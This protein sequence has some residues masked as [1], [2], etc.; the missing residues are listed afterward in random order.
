M[1]FLLVIIILTCALFSN[2]QVTP[3]GEFRVANS[4]TAMGV[5]LPVGTKVYN[6]ADGKYW[7]VTTAAPSTATLAVPGT[8]AFTQLNPSQVF[9]TLSV[10]NGTTTLSNSGGSMTIAGG[11][12]NSVTTNSNTITITGTEVDGSVS[13]EGSLSVGAGTASTSIINSNTS[14]STGVTITAGSGLGIS[15][16]G[17]VIT[18]TNSSPDQTVSITGAGINVASG[19]YPNFTITGTE[20]DGSITN[21]IQN[22]SYTAATRTLAIDGTGSTDAVLPLVDGT[23]PGLMSSSDF[24]KL[25]GI[26]TGA[27]NTNYKTEYFVEATT[28]AT[29]QTNTLSNTPKSATATQ[30]SLNGSVLRSSQYTIATNTLQITIPVYQHDSI[31][32]SYTY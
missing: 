1:K 32:I 25:S 5:N 22:L 24:T 14:G 29:G 19:T 17:N 28:S 26:A 13:N 31:A 2:A 15:E 4:T 11:G 30:V 20:V 21:E 16:T 27:T 9:Q 12:I 8:G 10:A 6:V 7:V 3:V 23:N 18:L